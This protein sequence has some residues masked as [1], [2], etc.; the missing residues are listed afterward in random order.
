MSVEQNLQITRAFH[1]NLLILSQSLLINTDQYMTNKK[2]GY[3]Q[4]ILN[5]RTQREKK[6][7]IKAQVNFLLTKFLFKNKFFRTS[8]IY[9]RYFEL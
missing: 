3:W 8:I 1:K 5:Q 7:Q 6:Q 4:T 9:S 2:P